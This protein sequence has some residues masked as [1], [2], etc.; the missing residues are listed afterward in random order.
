MPLSPL[1]LYDPVPH[2]C[3]KVTHDALETD[4]KT[5]EPPEAAAQSS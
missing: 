5:Q 3:L 4:K 2:T 1:E